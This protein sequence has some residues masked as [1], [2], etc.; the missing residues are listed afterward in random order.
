[1]LSTYSRRNLLSF[2]IGNKLK[3]DMSMCDLGQSTDVYLYQTAF[4]NHARLFDKLEHS[5]VLLM[6]EH[7]P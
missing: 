4:K 5:K 3:M 1:M 7:E 6:D 2:C